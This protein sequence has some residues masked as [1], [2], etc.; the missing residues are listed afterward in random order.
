M[1]AKLAN[2]RQSMARVGLWRTLIRYADA[3]LRRLM[4]YELCRVE[5]NCDAAYD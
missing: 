1:P 2:F 4:P 3:R 5:T